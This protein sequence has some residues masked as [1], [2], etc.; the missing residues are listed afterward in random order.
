MEINGIELK[1]IRKKLNLSQE[2]LAKK[3]GV[4]VRTVRNYESGEVIPISK[5]AILH[6][7][8]LNSENINQS[9]KGNNNNVIGGNNYNKDSLE[10]MDLKNQIKEKDKIISQLLDEQKKLHEQIN[11]LIDKLT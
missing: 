6:E 4:S 10:I 9:I 8:K 2:K 1:K 5:Q 7:L 3:I 11:K